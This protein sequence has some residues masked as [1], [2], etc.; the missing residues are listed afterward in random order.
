MGLGIVVGSRIKASVVSAILA[1]V[2]QFPLSVLSVPH[3][4]RPVGEVY[5]I[6]LADHVLLQAPL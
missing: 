6:G 5:A 4:S 2:L 1:S 3:L